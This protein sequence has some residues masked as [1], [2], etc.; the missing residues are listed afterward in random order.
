MILFS[1]NNVGLPLVFN[2]LNKKRFSIYM[3]SKL[4]DCEVAARFALPIPGGLIFSP[5]RRR[6]FIICQHFLSKKKSYKQT[7]YTQRIHC[8]SPQ[9][10]SI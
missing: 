8:F 3:I 10:P 9:F 1:D 7:L 6:I 2:S 4:T 5:C